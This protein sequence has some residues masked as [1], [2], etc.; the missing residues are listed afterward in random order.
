MRDLNHLPYNPDLEPSNFHDLCRSRQN[1]VN[2]IHLA[3]TS[4]H[5]LRPEIVESINTRSG[6]TEPEKWQRLVGHI[7]FNDI[8][9]KYHTIA[10]ILA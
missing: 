6:V 4:C 7:Y 3:S 9:L 10:L 5:A 1:F 2:N 8:L